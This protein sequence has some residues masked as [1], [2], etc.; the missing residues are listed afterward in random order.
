M[1]NK[2]IQ[3]IKID[4]REQLAGNIPERQTSIWYFMK[5]INN[6]AYQPDIIPADFSFDKIKQNIMVYGIKKL[7]DIA[8]QNKDYFGIISA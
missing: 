4:I 2:L 6:L 1:L 5:T 7:F 3:F 8:F